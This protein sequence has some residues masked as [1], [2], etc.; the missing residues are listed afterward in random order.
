MLTLPAQLAG[1][2][3]PQRLLGQGAI[4][5]VYLA[6]D[7]LRGRDVALKILYP[8]LRESPVVVERFRREVEITRRI[9]GKQGHPHVLAIA[10]VLDDAGL[11]FLVMEYHPGGDL[12]DRIATQGALPLP[13]LMALAHQLC[14]AL[15]VAHS[16]GIVHRDVKP[17][18]VLV[19]A[20]GPLDVRLC[21]FGLARSA[22]G[23]G[24]TTRMQVLGTPEYMA[25]EVIA[26]GHADARSDLYSLGVVLYEAA[27]A[28]L[29]FTADSP[30]RLMRL[31]LDAE[32]PSP[33]SH[34]PELPVA[35]ERALMQTLAKDPLDRPASADDLLAALQAESTIPQSPVLATRARGT[36]CQQCGG[37]MVAA[38]GICAD[39]GHQAL[40]LER[41]RPGC[42]VLVVG[43]GKPGDRIESRQ[44]VGLFRLLDEL[45]DGWRPVAKESRRLPRFPFF[46]ARR[47]TT[48]SAERLLARVQALGLEA[49]IHRG[50]P[51]LRK[52][53]RSKATTLAWRYFA[54]AGVFGW[55][56]QAHHLIPDGLLAGVPSVVTAALVVFG[57]PTLVAIG[58]S[59]S[60]SRSLLHAPDGGQAGALD[61]RI[62]DA[63]A[64]LRSRQDRRTLGRIGE[65]F[66]RLMEGAGAEPARRFTER[67]GFMANALQAV[68]DAD[69]A[70]SRATTTAADAE[71]AQSELRRLEQGRVLLRGELARLDRR[72]EILEASLTERG[73]HEARQEM[74]AAAEIAASLALEVAAT[75]ELDEFLARRALP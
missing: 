23:A 47:L 60:T 39:C 70:W 25:P 10:D 28:R 18:N 32:A 20:P 50:L 68:E 29:P 74:A 53:L 40:R 12:A 65:R 71:L 13:D 51:L 33:R 16:A 37:W 22:E 38:A 56:G 26:D 75:R 3:R 11:L 7:A 44:H 5:E 27:T 41:E 4:A 45:P 21:D 64:R 54:A 63:M 6:H 31:H 48:R 62:V 17:S 14:G 36:P 55:F 15:G 19:G 34:R 61:P 42:G 52:D 43:P 46:V 72:L 30:Y 8:A 66:V 2:Y 69:A 67:A 73:G 1:R 35:F 57:M 49:E 59:R 9:L 58:I 24:L